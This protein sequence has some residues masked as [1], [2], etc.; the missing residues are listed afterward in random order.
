MLNDLRIGARLALGF[1]CVAGVFLATLLVVGV[2][3]SGLKENVIQINDETLP[4]ILL[5]S[6]MNLSRS[7]VQ[8][9]LTDVSA[10]R[11]PAALAEAQTSAKRFQD[12]VAKFKH[13]FR[14]AGDTA[15][16]QRME[17]LEADFN[18]FYASGIRMA[19]AYISSGVAAGNL[20]MKGTASERG[21]DQTSEVIMHSLN[22]FQQS[23]ISQASQVSTGAVKNVNALLTGISAGSATAAV[24]AILLA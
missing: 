21:F 11:D 2:M 5:V 19:T 15:N 12:G 23:Q 1:A 18:V 22:A 16:Y 6:D 7:E 14:Q 8:Q 3:L 4:S 13:T 20:L 24:L 17:S 9:F 10:T